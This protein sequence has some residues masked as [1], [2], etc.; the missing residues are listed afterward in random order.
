MQMI[1]LWGKDRKLYEG[2][3]KDKCFLADFDE[4]RYWLIVQK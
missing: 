4:T 1:P 2:G 3:K